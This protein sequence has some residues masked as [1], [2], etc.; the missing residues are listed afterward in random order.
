[1]QEQNQW[2]E[3]W[4]RTRA[5]NGII[6]AIFVKKKEQKTG[7]EKVHVS[8]QSLDSAQGTY[9][10]LLW[11]TLILHMHCCFVGPEFFQ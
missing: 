10:A 11:H 8:Q 2:V 1:M 4:I 7:F 9:M 5:N 6:M 3:Y